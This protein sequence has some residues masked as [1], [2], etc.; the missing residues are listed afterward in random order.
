MAFVKEGQT[1][2]QLTWK[3]ITAAELAANFEALECCLDMVCL[4]GD[5][6]CV[7]SL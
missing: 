5:L 1:I 3:K 2:G 4:R 7:T 6:F